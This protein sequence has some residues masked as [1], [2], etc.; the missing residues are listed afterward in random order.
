MLDFKDVRKL[1]VVI[2][3]RRVTADDILRRAP[4]EDSVGCAS[5]DG[6]GHLG[7]AL[8]DDLSEMTRG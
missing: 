3:R 4:G 5:S 8:P 1:V 7:S 2:S 6:A